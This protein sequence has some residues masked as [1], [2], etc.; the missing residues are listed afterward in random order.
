ML[1]LSLFS[2]LVKYIYFARRLFTLFVINELRVTNYDAHDGTLCGAF[3]SC[4]K[5]YKLALGCIY[6]STS[7]TFMCVFDST[8]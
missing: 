1:N 2:D 5:C 7:A 8:F 4:H 3:F 6:F